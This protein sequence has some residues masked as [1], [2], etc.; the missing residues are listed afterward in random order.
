MIST[1]MREYDYYTYDEMNAYGQ[2]QLSE[3]PKG[4]IKMAINLISQAIGDNV[5]YADAQYSGLTFDAI[6]DT[7]VIQYGD[8]KIKVLGISHINR[9]NVALMKRM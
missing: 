8:E 4:K 5:L 1:Q 6:D 3:Q 2:P 7:Y 9:Y